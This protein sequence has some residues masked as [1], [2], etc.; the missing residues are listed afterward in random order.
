M[1]GA[2]REKRTRP[3]WC[4]SV[5]VAAPGPLTW[6][7][8]ENG[9]TRISSPCCRRAGAAICSPVQVR[10]VL[11][12]QILEDRFVT[13][14]DDARVISGDPQRFET[15]CRSRVPAEHVF[16][17]TEL[18]VAADKSQPVGDAGAGGLGSARMSGASQA[19]A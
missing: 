6:M 12:A 7:V 15:H 9:P 16:S 18:D 10:P 5:S 11:A 13:G 8:S 2:V 4:T 17:L 14:H 1:L 3:S 19:N